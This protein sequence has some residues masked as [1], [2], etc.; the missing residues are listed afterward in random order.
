MKFHL[1]S[2]LL[3]NAVRCPFFSFFW[4]FSWISNDKML[5]FLESVSF[6]MFISQNTEKEIIQQI[7]R[8]C[9]KEKTLFLIL[10]NG[11][12]S[13]WE[14]IFLTFLEIFEFLQF[15]TKRIYVLTFTLAAFCK[16]IQNSL[17]SLDWIM[18]GR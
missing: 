5:R 2:N 6:M 16:V 17:Q 10:Q 13:S 9:C 11:G 3:E 1:Y 14:K 12:G 7:S 8:I 4:S 15:S 18:Q